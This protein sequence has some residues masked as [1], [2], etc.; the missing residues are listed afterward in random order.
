MS[1]SEEMKRK[2]AAKNKKNDRK[3][4]KA[5]RVER[6]EKAAR[7]EE[8]YDVLCIGAGPTGLACAMEV[9]RAGMRPVVIDKGCLCNSI[10]HYPVNMM[11]FTTAERMEIGD[12]PLTAA[13]DK[14]SR[15]DALK[16]Y[17][18]GAEH[19][20]LDVRLYERVMKLSGEDGNFEVVTESEKGDPEGVGVVKGAGVDAEEEGE[21]ADSE[22]VLR[23]SLEALKR[24]RKGKNGGRA[25]AGVARRAPV[26]RTYGAK[27][28]IVAT[29][30]YDKPNLMGI[31]GEDLPHVS[32]YFTEP[33]PYW[34]RDVV[35][36][37]AKNSAA[38][39]ALE[40]FRGGSR[41]TLVHR[42][43]GMGGTLKY[44]VKPDIENRIKAGEIRAIFN[45]EVVRIEREK[46]W[47]R[48]H[49]GEH[50]LP[51]TQVFAMTGYHP[52]YSFLESIGLELDPES[53]KP[54]CDPVTLE[55][56][57]PGIY[58]AGVIIGGKQT[59]QIFIENG[60]FHGKQ[61]IAAL[62]GSKKDL[63]PAPVAA[64]GE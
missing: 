15:V 53:R 14:P 64:P 34:N 32:H 6:V 9:K 48:N 29:G 43:S 27:K 17:R 20:D 41:V 35:V 5:V 62:T 18:R 28:I 61:I 52:D 57:V 55:S 54:I 23:E 1:E 3:D 56:S 51:A 42:G 31:P 11:F 12:L 4:A 39:A 25:E 46:I 10:F 21:D 38:E 37:G 40:L 30:Y 33:H 22:V 16:Y 45:A 47:I 44:W 13:G 60:R 59:G 49:A 26:R 50:A 7:R 2:M 19:F 36:I 58:V 24:A 8:V 63:G